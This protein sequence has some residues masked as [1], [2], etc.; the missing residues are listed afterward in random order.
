MK[1][2]APRF[3]KQ[4][5]LPRFIA[6]ANASFVS[7]SSL[8]TLMSFC[9][10]SWTFHVDNIYS[11]DQGNTRVSKV[12]GDK[13]GKPACSKIRAVSLGFPTSLTNKR[14]SIGDGNSCYEGWRDGKNLNKSNYPALPASLV[15]GTFWGF[16]VQEKKTMTIIHLAFSQCRLVSRVGSPCICQF[17]HS[18]R[19]CINIP[20]GRGAAFIQSNIENFYCCL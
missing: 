5:H 13:P 15:W 19:I 3:W 1:T 7:G 8:I 18:R 12:G 4:R 20:S 16:S 6:T 2:S 9:H 14:I 17:C 11:S 10:L